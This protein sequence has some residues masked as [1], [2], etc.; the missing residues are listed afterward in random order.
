MTTPV[1]LLASHWLL[2]HQGG[3][4]EILLFVGPVALAIWGVRWAERRAKARR[5]A[6]GEAASVS[7]S[8]R[9]DQP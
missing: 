2:A 6:G 4:D 7:L 3:W 5:D 8:S 9:K 1:W